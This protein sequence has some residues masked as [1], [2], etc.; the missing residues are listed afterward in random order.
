MTRAWLWCLSL[1]LSAAQAEDRDP[2]QPPASRPQC[3]LP[4]KAGAREWRL[5]GTLSDQTHQ[6]AYITGPG[7]G[8]YFLEVGEYL[9]GTAWKAE[10]IHRGKV[11]FRNTPACDKPFWQLSLAR[12][13]PDEE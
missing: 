12:G 3:Q 10:S 5:Q 11:L 7:G 9:P 2:F 4:E 13:S 8:H 6:A 1:I